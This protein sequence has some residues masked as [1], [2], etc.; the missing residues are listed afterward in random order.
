L[1]FLINEPIQKPKANIESRSDF[2]RESDPGFM[3]FD[4]WA[5]V[6]RTEIFLV[7]FDRVVL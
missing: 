7:I 5:R 6:L 1:I 2:D 3:G 4:L